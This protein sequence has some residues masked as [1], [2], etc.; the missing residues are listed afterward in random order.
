MSTLFHSLVLVASLSSVASAAVLDLPIWVKNSYSLVKVAIGTPAE[1]YLLLFDTGSSTVWVRDEFCVTECNNYS[2]FPRNGYNAS[3]STTSGSLGTYAT[4]EY[5]GGDTSGS[6]VYDQFQIGDLTWNQTFMSVDVTDWAQ[7]AGDGFLGLAFSTI[8]DA[9]TT[10]LVETL[11]EEGA[12]DE[13]RFGLYYGKEFN[14]TGSSA[15]EGVLTLG[16]SKEDVY[17]EGNLTWVPLQ[18]RDNQ[19]QVWR[20]SLVTMSGFKTEV[21]GVVNETYV[22]LDYSWGVFDTGAGSIS[23]PENK[24]DEIYASIG[25]NYRAILE[26][27]HI[28]LCTEFNSSWSVAFRFGDILDQREIILTGEQLRRPGFAYRDDA[29][30]PPFNGGNNDGFFLFGTPLLRQM[31][32][33]WDFGATDVEEYRPQVGFGALKHEYSPL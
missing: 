23:V 10:T 21:D 19:Y 29:C 12:L 24:V 4:I 16:G 8:S 14:D 6:G 20:S 13:P 17:V 31:Y 5:L 1:E 27:G 28:P 22:P 32:S 25:M 18:T 33:V 30:W 9:N 3:A 7:T 15:G 11:I 26:G 2:G